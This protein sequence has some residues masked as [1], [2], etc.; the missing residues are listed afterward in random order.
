M[1]IP[2]AISVFSPIN[3]TSSLLPIE[4]IPFKRLDPPP[5]LPSSF[6]LSKSITKTLMGF[7]FL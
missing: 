4:I 7:I 5:F 6:A 1:V 3:L 2:R